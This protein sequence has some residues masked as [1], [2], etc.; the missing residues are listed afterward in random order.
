MLIERW[1][2]TKAQQSLQRDSTTPNP[3]STEGHGPMFDPRL[4]TYLLD[5][6]GSWVKVE[7]GAGGKPIK[8]IHD[9]SSEIEEKDFCVDP[10][11]GK[12]AKYV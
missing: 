7:E 3:N 1:E 12:F 8:V 6:V 4:S 5:P 11:F 2:E 9:S 10:T